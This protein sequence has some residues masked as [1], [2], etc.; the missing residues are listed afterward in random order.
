MRRRPVAGK[1]KI[2]MDY[3]MACRLLHSVVEVPEGAVRGVGAIGTG[4]MQLEGA[5]G[6][7]GT[8][9]LSA[10]PSAPTNPTSESPL[11]SSGGPSSKSDGTTYV[12]EIVWERFNSTACDQLWYFES[13]L[14]VFRERSPGPMLDDLA[15]V[16][17]E[18]RAR[19]AAQ[20]PAS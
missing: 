19:H 2:P 10:A 8:I 15:E 5:V 16:V 13:L 3:S 17:G 1:D 7:T 4:D 11:P 12:G 20:P 9:A 14:T 6:A 18:V